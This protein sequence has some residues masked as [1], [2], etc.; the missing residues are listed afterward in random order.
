LISDLQDLSKR[1]DLYASLD[2]QVEELMF[3][4][5][6]VRGYKKHLKSKLQLVE[7]V[8]SDAVKLEAGYFQDLYSILE[9]DAFAQGGAETE[10][11]SFDVAYYSAGKKNDITIAYALD[12]F[13]SKLKSIPI[14]SPVEGKLT[15]TYGMRPHPVKKTRKMHHGIDIG[16]A[17]GAT[18]RSVA[19][20]VVV[21][22]EWMPGYGYTI[23]LDHGNGYQT[24]YGH[25]SRIDVK[26]GQRVCRGQAVAL[27]GSTGRSTGPHLHYEVRVKGKPKNPL[28]FIKLASKLKVI[29]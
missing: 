23:L 28:P 17:R 27:I 26:K 20:A 29:S 6:D 10:E 16:I 25:L 19:D 18:V 2:S 15:S 21:K 24:L 9:E 11:T 7:S 22:A 1:E 12:K 3:A 13:S 14:G 5:D 8:L 4:T